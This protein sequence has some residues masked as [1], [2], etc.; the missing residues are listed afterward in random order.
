ML[1]FSEELLSQIS[2]RSL[3]FRK[4]EIA[5]I[6]PT[7]NSSCFKKKMLLKNWPKRAKI[8]LKSPGKIA[9]HRTF[10]FKGLKLF[11]FVKRI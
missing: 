2:A 8:H 7:L 6:K 3:T 9:R 10:F 5:E 11:S 1:S 4:L